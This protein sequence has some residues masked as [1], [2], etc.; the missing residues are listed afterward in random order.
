MLS[1]RIVNLEK[2]IAFKR[3][4]I[5]LS[6]LLFAG[7]NQEFP[8]RKLS[9]KILLFTKQVEKGASEQTVFSL[10]DGINIFYKVDSVDADLNGRGAVSLP[11][12][13]GEFSSEISTVDFNSISE[14][15]TSLKISA[16]KTILKK[17]DFNGN[18][19]TPA[20]QEVYVAFRRDLLSG[21]KR[22]YLSHFS[23][24]ASNAEIDTA[25]AASVSFDIQETS[26]LNP[27]SITETPEG[28]ILIGTI[29]QG[30]NPAAVK[31]LSY[32]GQTLTD[33]NV[34]NTPGTPK[35]VNLFYIHD[36]TLLMVV[37]EG[38]APIPGKIYYSL[39]I[40]AAQA[41]NY[42][43]F[44]PKAGISTWTQISNTLI[45]INEDPAGNIY[46][47]F[48]DNGGGG[49]YQGHII[50][51]QISN[52]IMQDIT[53]TT[54]LFG[55]NAIRLWNVF[56][57]SFDI[58]FFQNG[59]IFA[60]FQKVG[61]EVNFAHKPVSKNLFEDKGLSLGNAPFIYY[62][63][64]MEVPGN[65]T[66]DPF[67]LFQ[68]S[69]NNFASS[70][71]RIG[72]IPIYYGGEVRILDWNPDL[73]LE[74]QTPPF[75]NSQI[76]V[77][78]TL[79]E[80]I[81]VS[82][83][84]NEKIA[85]DSLITVTFDTD[86]NQGSINNASLKLLDQNGVP[87]DCDIS[88]D[89]KTNVASLLPKKLLPKNSRIRLIASKD[90]FHANGNALYTV[91]PLNIFEAFFDVGE[92]YS[93]SSDDFQIEIYSDRERTRLISGFLSQGTYYFSIKRKNTKVELPSSI[94]IQSEEL[95]Q[96]FEVPLSM[97]SP[98]NEAYGEF[99][100]TTGG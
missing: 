18:L 7:A 63:G 85:R 35:G 61:G 64:L 97:E 31:I 25:L 74:F 55:A 29:T 13:E 47:A 60:V 53:P 43:E 40:A 20:Q 41:G 82:P 88:Y 77:Q 9:A 70:A 66:L 46:L 58:G 56:P 33:L 4:L 27:V 5:I 94:F 75:P 91:P 45:D 92:D 37:A 28:K 16:A 62:P 34:G 99:R 10:G 48:S 79:P 50:K 68:Y 24:G 100:I 96:S 42:L 54:N 98:E 65:D 44:T 51:V 39:S 6:Y 21:D 38:S 73:I 72:K 36:G 15:S 84:S 78:A 67:L 32:D 59:A 11:L 19:L 57:T 81:A 8:G 3:T 26:A 52:G 89:S 49:N 2:S 1:F 12:R 83:S 76:K 86:L 22:F 14:Y 71:L 69:D 30:G 23:P 87:I 17:K 80:I 90:I 93:T 95:G